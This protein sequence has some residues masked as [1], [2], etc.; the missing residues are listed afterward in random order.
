M[1]SLGSTAV[2]TPI[3]ASRFE[4]ATRWLA[5]RWLNRIIAGR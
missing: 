2:S 4:Y 1:P 5:L 3:A